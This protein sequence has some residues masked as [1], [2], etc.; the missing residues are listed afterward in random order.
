MQKGCLN[1]DSRNPAA[2]NLSPVCGERFLKM[3]EG[4]QPEKQFKIAE[5]FFRNREGEEQ[6]FRAAVKVSTKR[7]YQQMQ[8]RNTG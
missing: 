1:T 7:M 5:K 3:Y 8:T 4:N 2:K 6:I